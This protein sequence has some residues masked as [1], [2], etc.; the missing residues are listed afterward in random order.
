MILSNSLVMPMILYSETHS[1]NAF[2]E[3]NLMDNSLPPVL[4]DPRVIE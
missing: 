2:G 3:T 1:I 4:N